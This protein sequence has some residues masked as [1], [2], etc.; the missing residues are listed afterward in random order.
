MVI[1]N[2][3][4]RRILE[5]VLILVFRFT[6]VGFLLIGANDCASKLALFISYVL[7]AMAEYKQFYCL[8]IFQLTNEAGAT[9]RSKTCSNVAGETEYVC[10]AKTSDFTVKVIGSLSW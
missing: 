10:V 4:E 5:G 8:L 3:L 6:L 2:S 7:A 1:Y 9:W